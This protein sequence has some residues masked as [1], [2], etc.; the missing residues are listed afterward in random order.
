MTY[1]LGDAARWEFLFPTMDKPLLGLPAMDEGNLD[2]D[3]EEVRQLTY[4]ERDTV[5]H[6]PIYELIHRL[7]F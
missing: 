7:A 2:L 5:N 3:D 1:D 4:H 6:C